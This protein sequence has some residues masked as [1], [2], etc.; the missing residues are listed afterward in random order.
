MASFHDSLWGVE[1]EDYGHSH[2][3]CSS[4]RMFRDYAFLSELNAECALMGIVE[5]THV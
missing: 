5:G 3:H 4:S 1:V 2:G